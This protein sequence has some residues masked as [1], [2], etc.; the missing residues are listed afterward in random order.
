MF[1]LLLLCHVRPEMKGYQRKIYFP[2]TLSASKR[3]C[4]I[5]FYNSYLYHGW[6]SAANRILLDLIPESMS[7]EACVSA[8]STIRQ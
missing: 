1:V 4:F 3:H 6:H 5:Q 8:C 2:A 7:N